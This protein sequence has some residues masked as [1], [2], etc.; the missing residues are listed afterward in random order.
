MVLQSHLRDV[1]QDPDRDHVHRQAGRPLQVAQVQRQQVPV[2]ETPVLRGQ[3]EEGEGGGE[4]EG[5][6][7]KGE[8]GGGE[9]TNEMHSSL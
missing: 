5:E 8:R 4:G 3:G 2:Q 7:E 6:G 9:L 1:P